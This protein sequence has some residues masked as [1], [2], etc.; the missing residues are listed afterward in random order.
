MIAADTPDVPRKRTCAALLM[1][2]AVAGLGGGAV[3]QARGVRPSA[4]AIF[5][6]PPELPASPRSRETT[7]AALKAS[8]GGAAAFLESTAQ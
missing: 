5:T 2:G 6:H 3:D 4:N 1:L 8:T 7:A